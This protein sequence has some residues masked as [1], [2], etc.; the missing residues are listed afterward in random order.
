MKTTNQE[1]KE[2]KV[3]VANVV[4]VIKVMMNEVETQEDKNTVRSIVDQAIC[5][6]NNLLSDVDGIQIKK[7]EKADQEAGDIVLQEQPSEENLE[8]LDMMTNVD[9]GLMDLIKKVESSKTNK[10]TNEINK[11]TV[12]LILK[13]VRKKINKLA[14][15]RTEEYVKNDKKLDD[16]CDWCS[17]ELIKAAASDN[18]DKDYV[19]D[20]LKD[21]RNAIGSQIIGYGEIDENGDQTEE[22]ADKLKVLE[23]SNFCRFTINNE[24]ELRAEGFGLW[25]HLHTLSQDLEVNYDKISDWQYD[26]TQIIDQLLQNIKSYAKINNQELLEASNEWRLS[27]SQ[28]IGTINGGY[29]DINNEET[30]A[31]ERRDKVLDILNTIKDDIQ[32]KIMSGVVEEETTDEPSEDEEIDTDSDHLENAIECIEN[33]IEEFYYDRWEK[34]LRIIT[35]ASQGVNRILGV[36]I[37]RLDRISITDNKALENI[38]LDCKNKIESTI[39]LVATIPQYHRSHKGRKSEK[40]TRAVELIRLIQD[41]PIKLEEIRDILKFKINPVTKEDGSVYLECAKEEAIEPTHTPEVDEPISHEKV[42]IIRESAIEEIQDLISELEGIEW[43]EGSD[44]SEE[45]LLQEQTDDIVSRIQEVSDSLVD[46]REYAIE[47]K[48]EELECI[49]QANKDELYEAL[50]SASGMPFFNLEI[51]K[52]QADDAIDSLET[53]LLSLET[54]MI[55]KED[56]S[57]CSKPSTYVAVEETTT[58]QQPVSDRINL[59]LFSVFQNEENQI[60]EEEIVE[61]AELDKKIK[62]TIEDLQTQNTETETITETETDD[63]WVDEEFEASEYINSKFKLINDMDEKIRKHRKDEIKLKTFFA[64]HNQMFELMKEFIEDDSI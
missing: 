48:D 63:E 15:M 61:D 30:T 38:I 4:E 34:S 24:E 32:V 6:L 41:C 36:A 22:E 49:C 42:K 55:E 19:L 13:I 2:V 58:P 47:Q 28:I 3:A 54:S 23:P 9:W 39:D 7:E 16:M 29:D 21:V 44:E 59:Q 27:I 43:E 53:V 33:C 56:G 10:N 5:A 57:I 52:E 40:Q 17:D 62:Q 1:N 35:S 51:V 11:T 25:K 45:K 14:A 18:K 20:K 37:E 8:I 26:R 50:A 31:I 46:M 64:K 60:L 12:N